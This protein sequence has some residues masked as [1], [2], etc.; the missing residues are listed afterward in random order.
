M[1][2]DQFCRTDDVRR[3]DCAGGARPFRSGLHEAAFKFDPDRE[4]TGQEDAYQDRRPRR[5][6]GTI[7]NAWVVDYR[8][9][10][11]KRRSR[12][13]ARKREAKDFQLTA[14]NEV[15]LGVHSVFHESP[16]VASAAGFWLDDRATAGLEPTTLAS[17]EQHVRLHIVPTCGGMRLAEL[18]A[19]KASEISRR[20]NKGLSAPMAKRV[21][22]SF[23]A[24]VD[25]AMRE[26]RVAQNAVSV[27]KSQ[28]SKR[29][30]QRDIP[31]KDMLR[32]ILGRADRSNVAG[33]RPLIY[34]MIFTGLRVSELRALQWK[35]INF[36]RG[37]LSVKRRANNRGSLGPPKSEAG[38]RTIPLSP[39]TLGVL[40]D[41]QHSCPSSPMDLLFPSVRARV[42]AY[43]VMHKHM[44]APIVHGG[45]MDAVEAQRFG[46]HDFRHAAASLW[47]EQN[48]SP[49]KVQ[50]LMGHSSIT[51]TFDTYGHLFTAREGDGHIAE[52]MEAGIF[53]G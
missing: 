24:I 2:L 44:F 14:E 22:R 9:Q 46:F 7:K 48:L 49:K 19:P 23:K 30:M 53:E 4:P 25:L 16:T 38:I 26:G 18:T 52:A 15:R 32:E 1:E 35:D 12:Q 33:V 40:K 37:T 45:G 47:I 42:M 3:F 36:V 13:F 41:W 43:E 51:M 29:V 28:R 5:K 34:L 20:W 39:K 6:S 50:E 11:G 27:V 17:Y 8:D 10:Q 31:S 21:L